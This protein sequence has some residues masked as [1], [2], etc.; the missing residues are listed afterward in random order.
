[1]LAYVISLLDGNGDW[2]TSG[3]NL[4]SF[5]Q[6]TNVASCECDHLTNFALLVVGKL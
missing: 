2:N 4:M 1:M 3:C 5:N 6:S